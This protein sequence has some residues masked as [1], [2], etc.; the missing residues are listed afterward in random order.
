LQTRYKDLKVATKAVDKAIEIYNN[1]R[2]HLSIGMLTPQ[3]AHQ[4]QGELKMLWKKKQRQPQKR[5]GALLC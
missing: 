1:K 5:G 4:R 3:K 2:P